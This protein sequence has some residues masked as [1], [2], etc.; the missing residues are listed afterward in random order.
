MADPIP[1]FVADWFDHPDTQREIGFARD[2]LLR[3][4]STMDPVLLTMMVEILSTMQWG[5]PCDCDS[6]PEDDRVDD[7]ESWKR[8]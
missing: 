5:G 1:S 8:R 7:D 6:E 3:A 4:K 2:R